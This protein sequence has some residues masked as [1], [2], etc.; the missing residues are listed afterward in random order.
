M[1][2][3]IFLLLKPL[4]SMEYEDKSTKKGVLLKRKDEK[5]KKD[6]KRNMIL[7]F[8]IFVPFTVTIIIYHKNLYFPIY[9]R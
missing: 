9:K 8:A 2:E 3:R 5:D 6:R 7:P 1:L 4:E